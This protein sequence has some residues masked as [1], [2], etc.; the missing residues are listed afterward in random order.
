MLS[1]S[2]LHVKLSFFYG[3]LAPSKIISD[4]IDTLLRMFAIEI[5]STQYRTL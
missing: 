1:I 3:L 4:A 5:H 2:F